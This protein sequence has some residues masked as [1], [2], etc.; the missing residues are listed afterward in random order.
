M[1]SYLIP[2]NVTT[3]L[4]ENATFMIINNEFYSQTS[5]SGFILYG[6]LNGSIKIQVRILNKIKN[7]IKS[8]F[9]IKKIIFLRLFL[10]MYVG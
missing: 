5:L 2:K 3:I 7:K 4:N 10:Q 6:A 9:Q 1:K 8:L